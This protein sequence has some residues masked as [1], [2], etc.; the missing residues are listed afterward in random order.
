MRIEEA[1]ALGR[2]AGH[3]AIRPV[4]LARDMQAAIERRTF[5]LLGPLGEPVRVVQ[6]GISEVAYRSVAAALRT[7]IGAGATALLAAGPDEAPLADTPRGG[8]ALGALNGAI[9]D[10]L[11]R[12][13]EP[14]A[15]EMTLQREDHEPSARLAVFV[16]GL[17]ETDASWKLFGRPTYGDLLREELGYTPVYARYNTGLH[18]SD[19]GRRLAALLDGLVE[20]WPVELESVA[21][22]GHSMGGLVVRSACHYG[23]ADGHGWVEPL[24][25]VFCLGTP[26]LGA[27]LEKAANVAGWALGRLPESRPFAD[28]INVR[29]AG[30]KD[31]RFGS[32]IEEDWRDH[33]PDEL[34][35][36]RCGEVPFL[37][38]A[39]YFYIGATL[40]QSA[41]D[42][43]GSLVGDLLVRLPSASGSGRT[44][45]IPFELDKGLH[46]GGLTHFHLLG[47]PRVYEQIRLWIEHETS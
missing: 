31:L 36:D 10:R 22:V 3:A 19:N 13:Y 21:L 9:G 16:H 8:L 26:H 28:A 11:A 33:D 46:L 1:K 47:H 30:I 32:C 44:R 25:H 17:C 6:R 12:E 7:P 39:A 15:L 27:P 18:I 4:V 24:R 37:P 23:E 42:R 2:L 29:S 41:D 20:E 35:R 43:L 5:E 38:H 14:V 34:L 40:A 45:R